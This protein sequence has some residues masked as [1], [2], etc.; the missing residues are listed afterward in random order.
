MSSFSIAPD[1]TIYDLRNDGTLVNWIGPG[2]PLSTFDT[3]VSTFSIAPDGTIYDL[4]NDGTLVNWIG[5]GSPLATVDVLVSYFA[6]K[7]NGELSVVDWF[8]QNLIDPTLQ[9]LVRARVVDDGGL[10]RADM[11]EVFSQVGK[12]GSVSTNEFDDLRAIV[13]NQVTLKTA[14]DVQGLSRSVVCGDGAGQPFEGRLLGNLAAGDSATKLEQLV[15]KW[16]YGADH[17]LAETPTGLIAPYQQV[18]SVPLFALGGPK[19]EDVGQGAEG[20]CW[21]LASFAATAGAESSRRPK[22]VY[23]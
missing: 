15:G 16:F 7:P 2:S 11:L 8:T 5:P 18:T 6:L 14:L 10:T 22:Y 4:R 17:P 1:G 20:D 21:L 23:R 12:D 9:S 3:H 19:F 13:D